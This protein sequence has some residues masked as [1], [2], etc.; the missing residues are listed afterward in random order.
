MFKTIKRIIDWCGEFKGRLY[1]GFVFSFFSYWFTA[2]PIMI[3]AYLVSR[4][5]L[6]EQ[7]GQ[8]L[9]AK[10]VP[11]SILLVLLLI[12]LRFLF[13]YLRARFQEAT[14]KINFILVTR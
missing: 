4:L 2:A 12:F 11:L 8:P 5:I 14:N 1:L 7:G 6:A 10:W 13:D 9:A 3:A